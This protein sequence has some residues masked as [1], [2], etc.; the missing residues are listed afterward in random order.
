MSDLAE[1]VR[2]GDPDRHAATLAAPEEVRAKLW[3][4]YAFNLEIARAPWVTQEPMIAEMRLQFW[5]DV[6]DGI[7]EGKPARAHEVAAPLS[8]VWRAAGLPIALGHNMIA[9]RRRDIYKEPFADAAELDAHLDATSGS[10]MWLAAL[11]LGAGQQAEEPVRD[12]AYAIGLSNWLQAVPVLQAHGHHPLPDA[13]DSAIAALARSGLVRMKRARAARRNVPADVGVIML[14]G[15]QAGPV[16]R[17]ATRHPHLV[18]SGG[19]ALSE[20]SRRGRLLLRALTG[21]W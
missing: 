5:A 13:S 12:M 15:W 6:L 1:I 2:L 16:L 7:A 20:F 18:Q 21:R 19:L 3:P 4:L 17:R 10:L 14:T 9:A 8:A 11:A